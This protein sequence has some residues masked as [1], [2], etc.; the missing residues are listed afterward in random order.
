MA[1]YKGRTTHHCP[2]KNKGNCRDAKYQ[3]EGFCA[4]H[5]TLCRIH[6]VAHLQSEY[7]FRCLKDAEAAQAA[8]R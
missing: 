5:Q 4:T 6:F 1:G 8:K 7:C 2:R 3:G